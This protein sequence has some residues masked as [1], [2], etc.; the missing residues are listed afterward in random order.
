MR[1]L[2]VALLVSLVA[3]SGF[4]IAWADPNGT[5]SPYTTTP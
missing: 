4:G 5:Q 3:F 2:A 1:G